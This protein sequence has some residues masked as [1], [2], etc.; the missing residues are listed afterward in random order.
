[1][2]DDA[3]REL[4]HRLAESSAPCEA[5][6]MSEQP[7]TPPDIPTWDVADRMRKALRHAGVG[8]AEMADYLGVDRSTV[9][10]WINGRIAPSGQTLRL[11]AIR[12]GVDLGWLAGARLLPGGRGFKN[13]A[14]LTAPGP[15]IP[16]SDGYLVLA[17]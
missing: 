3:A 11:W 10:T 15:C 2:W 14:S 12:T 9:S 4:A 17:A 5:L 8:V 16:F 1:M 6:R 7:A 13:R